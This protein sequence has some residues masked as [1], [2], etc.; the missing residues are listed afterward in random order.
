MKMNQSSSH[1]I[2]VQQDFIRKRDS[3][4]SFTS[5]KEE[6]EENGYQDKNISD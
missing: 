6:E 1:A 4:D 2:K 3:I 5:N